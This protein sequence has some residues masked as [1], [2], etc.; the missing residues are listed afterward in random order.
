MNSSTA[1]IKVVILGS[2]GS[3]G[4]QA[5]DIIRRNPDIFRVIGLSSSGRNAELFAQQVNEFSP[6]YVG[7]SLGTCAQDVQMRILAHAKGNG[8]SSG[9]SA[10]PEFLIGPD[11]SNSLAAVGADVVLNAIAGAAGLVPTLMALRSGA[12]L[13][14]ANKESLIIGGDL[15][16]AVA[17]P[18]QIVPVDSEHAALAQCLLAGT[19]SEVKSLI[20]TASGGPFRGFTSDQ[21][22]GVTIEQALAHPTWSMGP[23]VTINSATMV[24]KGLELIEAHL[25]F[26]IPF[27]QIEVVIH[28]ESVVHSMVEFVDG[29]TIAQA[30]PPDMRIPIAWG[31]GSPMRIPHAAPP[32][33]WSKATSWHFLPVDHSAFPAI[34]LA[35]VAGEAGGSAPAVF[36]GA[37][38]A[39]VGL[40]LEGSIGFTSIVS[41]IESTLQEH[42][43]SRHVS[44]NALTL[45]SVQ[46][47][48]AW[49]RARVSEL[50][51]S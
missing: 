28:P 26:D 13:A 31:L 43:E 22:N 10:T 37:D 4:I 47:A 30:S 18:G 3:I 33:D 11:S 15:V 23:L 20:L 49:A 8:F 14:L 21:L 39:A 36:N 38:E 50:A 19:R 40:F 46:E 42:L 45:E 12:R 32:C 35:R 6:D 9:H 29:S 2:T 24:N 44:G 1:M 17:E 41:L 27:S 48:D 7:I 25:L 34:T 51:K 5:L 16:R